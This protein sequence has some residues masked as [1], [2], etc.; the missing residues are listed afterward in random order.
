MEKEK[1][2]QKLID[3]EGG[4][5]LGI[6]DNKGEVWLGVKKACTDIG[7]TIGQADRQIKNI[8]ND[9]VLSKGMTNMT[10]PTNGG[11]QNVFAIHEYYV[12]LWLAKISLTPTMKEENPEAVERLVNY[13]LKCKDVLYKAFFETDEQKEQF[14]EDFG[15]KGQIVKLE[16][17]VSQLKNEIT[18]NTEKLT[19]TQNKLDSFI[20]VSTINSYQASKLLKQARERVSTIL[21]GAHSKLYKTESRKYFK[22]LWLNVSEKFEVSSYKDLNP[23]V[24]G[25]A[26]TFISNWSFN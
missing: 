21:G 14:A 16:N 18:N 22:N 2:Q 11:Q 20:D 19:S 12:T 4:Q 3:F 26:S 6:K 25:S 5:I 13:Q 10:F 24:F 1:L 17:E 7:L 9:V 15:L 8:K 23:L